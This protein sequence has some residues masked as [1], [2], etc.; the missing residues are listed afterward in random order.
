M[1]KWPGTFGFFENIHVMVELMIDE[2][3]RT[4]SWDSR[5]PGVQVYRAPG[6]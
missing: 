3:L 5:N 6:H 1:F 2:E 4:P